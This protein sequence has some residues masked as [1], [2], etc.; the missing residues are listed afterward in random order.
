MFS[1]M[2][3]PLTK[4]K[5]AM[6]DFTGI[7]DG[8]VLIAQF[9]GPD[10]RTNASLFVAAPAMYAALKGIVDNGIWNAEWDVARAVIAKVDGA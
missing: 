7:F 6:T 9:Y 5:M 3:W 4:T 2:R 10:K 1:V 8:Q